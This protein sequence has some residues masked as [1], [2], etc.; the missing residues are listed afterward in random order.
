MVVVSQASAGSGELSDNLILGQ[1]N[2]VDILIFPHTP[3][4]IC[5]PGAAG[6][7]DDPERVCDLLNNI[8]QQPLLLSLISHP[9]L[10]PLEQQVVQ[11][12]PQYQVEHQ[13]HSKSRCDHCPKA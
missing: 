1:E 12:Q 3:D 6:D 4:H 2:L 8:L 7:N 5:N 10:P 11:V 13:H 9:C